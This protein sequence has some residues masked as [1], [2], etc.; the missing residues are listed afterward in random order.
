MKAHAKGNLVVLKLPQESQLYYIKVL[1]AQKKVSCHK[2]TGCP[3]LCHFPTFASVWINKIL[4]MS[5]HVLL[6]Q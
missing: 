1:L 5:F 4:T 6:S 2:I 3:N